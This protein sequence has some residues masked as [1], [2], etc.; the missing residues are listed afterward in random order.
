[1][2]SPR[3]F[4][5]LLCLLPC[6]LLFPACESFYGEIGGADQTH[7][8]DTPE[9]ITERIGLWH[10]VWLA[11][12]GARITAG[13]TIGKW[14]ELETSIGRQKL[15]LWINNGFDP[16]HPRFLNGDGDPVNAVLLE[17]DSPS[18]CAEGTLCDEDYFIYYDDTWFGQN[19]A[20]VSGS[21][22]GQSWIGIVRAVN[23]F[24]NDPK[25]GSLIVEY[26]DGCFPDRAP[27]LAGPQALSFYGIYFRVITDDI[28]VFASP[29]DLAARINGRP[30]HTERATLAEAITLNNVENDI[31]FVNWGEELPFD[32]EGC[33][34]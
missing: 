33:R 9:A 24:D 31:E 5:P 14:Y 19:A 28:I 34:Q 18:R 11:R 1:V 4:P 30:S 7:T 25:R 32:R 23:I 10:D 27:F 26:L 2:N 8:F 15:Q 3:R 21:V 12:Y 6:L 17:E 29:L 16:E 13:F 20:N 22:R